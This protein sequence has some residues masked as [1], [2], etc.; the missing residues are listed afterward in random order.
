MLLTF[1]MNVCVCVPDLVKQLLLLPL[2]LL[3][4]RSP[5]CQSV[6]V[7]QWKYN[8]LLLGDIILLCLC[9]N[10]LNDGKGWW[11]G[12][13]RTQGEMFGDKSEMWSS[14]GEW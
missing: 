5:Q 7:C 6:C 8:L 14:K 12:D 3:F 10:D 1:A 13:R 9:A 4:V 2:L 11:T